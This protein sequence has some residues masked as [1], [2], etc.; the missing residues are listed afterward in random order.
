MDGSSK[1][2]ST[3]LT[4]SGFQMLRVREVCFLMQLGK[5][6]R[7]KIHKIPYVSKD[8]RQTFT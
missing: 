6:Y 1:H 4:D 2:F 8:H 5:S 3:F 7:E